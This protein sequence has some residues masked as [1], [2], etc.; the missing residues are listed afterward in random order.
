MFYQELGIVCGNFS[1]Q[2]PNS[3]KI[4]LALKAGQRGTKCLTDKYGDDLVCVRY[5]HGAMA[6]T[7][8]PGT[9]VLYTV[10]RISTRR[11]STTG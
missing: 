11:F 7:E 6:R 1:Q 3:L 5:R 2:E 4:R 10:T 8:I 9:G